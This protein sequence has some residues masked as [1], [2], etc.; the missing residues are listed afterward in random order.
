MPYILP[1]TYLSVRGQGSNR[2]QRSY[3]E[4]LWIDHGHAQRG[5]FGG[6][7]GTGNIRGSVQGRALSTGDRI[8]LYGVSWRGDGAGLGENTGTAIDLRAPSTQWR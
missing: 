5:D 3:L 7:Y 6:T 4:P 1:C 8:V 2:R